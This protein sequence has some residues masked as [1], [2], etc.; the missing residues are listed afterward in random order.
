MMGQYFQ[1]RRILNTLQLNS[2]SQSFKYNIKIYIIIIQDIQLA[3]Q[4][5]L[6]W[7]LGILMTWLVWQ[8]RKGNM[9]ILVLFQIALNKRLMIVTLYSLIWREENT[10][11]KRVELNRTGSENIQIELFLLSRGRVFFL[12]ANYVCITIFIL[13]MIQSNQNFIVCNTRKRIL[14]FIL[15]IRALRKRVFIPMLWLTG[16]A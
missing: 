4:L 5:Y 13:I 2:V 9:G 14:D 15:R 16:K 10:L 11:G 8:T 1:S 3:Y 6:G 7:C 12:Y